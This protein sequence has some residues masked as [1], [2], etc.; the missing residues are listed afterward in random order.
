[1]VE[2]MTDK[3]TVEIPAPAAG[4][5]KELRAKP[6]DVVPVGSVLFLLETGA[7]TA[8]VPQPHAAPATPAK[9]APVAAAPNAAH[10]AS[11]PAGGRLE[12]KLP[13][14]GEGVAEGEI[15]KWLVDAGASVK[16][17]QAV[18]EVMTDKATVEIPAPAA[19]KVL[20]LRASAG[21][22]VPVGSVLFVLETAAAVAA[23][24]AHAPA[25]AAPALVVAASTAARAKRT[26]DERV[27]AV[28]SARRVARDLGI[29]LGMVSGSGRNGIVRRAD[30]ESFAKSSSAAPASSPKPAAAA[31]APSKP[32]AAP[33]SLTP[34][35]RE[36]RIPFRGVRRKISEAMV[37][38]KFT[39]PHFTVV[40]EL[41]VTDLVRLREQAKA[42]GQESGVKVTFM[43]F[44]MKACALGLAKY[45][46]LNGHLD[47][48]AQEIVR[49]GYVDLG[50][51]MDT[52]NGLIVP[53]IRD[54]QSKGILQLAS[55]LHELAER[56]R[57]GKVKPDE[58]KGST[59][60]ITNAGNIG[61]TLA[62]P[63]I[64]FPDIAIM[65]VHRIV[66]RPGVVETPQGDKIEVRQYM[67]IS[68]SVDHRLADG[69]DGARF[70]VHVKRLLENPGLLAL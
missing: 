56:T 29:E 24:P 37:R 52:D 15:V 31:P 21:Q 42:L 58:L 17:H 64:N 6:G 49:C 14:I 69:A 27:L 48:A 22:V 5:V 7:A 55:E 20:E 43:P 30:V 9:S 41:D 53:V 16:E 68:C 26:S 28:P 12:F 18:V 62:T 33:I 19:G 70:L 25:H 23:T 65:G 50:I 4:T 45:P 40:E 47:E 35:E 46:M 36:T 11:K 57:A 3:A 8:P 44:I 51:A 66:K 60:S 34:R 63:I 67:N 1:V 59:F 61:G 54:V 2:V 39:A 10:G 32:A 38:S 13:D